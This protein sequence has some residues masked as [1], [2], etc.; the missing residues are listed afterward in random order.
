MNKTLLK[1][2]LSIF[3][4]NE[5]L[6][7]EK[8]KE[9]NSENNLRSLI[10]TIFL[11]ASSID[12]KLHTKLLQTVY[13]ESF[14]KNY[15]YTTLYIGPNKIK[16]TYIL[17]TGSSIMSSPCAPCDKCGPH[18]NNYYNSELPK[19]SKPLK[20]DN[21]PCKFVP[22]TNCKYKKDKEENKQLC[23]FD[24]K[25]Q[26]DD[27]MSGYYLNDIVYFE[28]DTNITSPIQKQV[29]RS[30]AL[31]IGCTT[32]EYGKYKELNAD[33]IIGL[34]YNEKSFISLLYNLKIINQD[35]FSLCFGLRGGYMSLGEVDTTYHKN[36]K[37]DYVPLLTSDEFYLI[38]IKGIEI[39]DNN[40]T[41]YSKSEAIIDTGNTISYFPIY[42]YKS[43]IKEFNEYCKKNDGKCG[44][45]KF[46]QELGYCA[47]F[48]DRGSLFKTIYKYWPNI[49]LELS[50]NKKYIWKPINYYYYSFEK[51]TRKRKACLGFNS[52]KSQ[53]IILG[54]NFIHDHDIIFDRAN[55]QLGFVQADCSRGNI[56]WKRR[57]GFLSKLPLLRNDPLLIDRAIHMGENEGKYNF[58]DNNTKDMLDFIQ[59]HNTELDFS[60]DF[61]LVNFIVLLSSI[62]VVVVVFAI[63]ISALMCNKRGYLKYDIP[64]AGQYME[65]IRDENATNKISFE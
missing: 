3:L 41:I 47:S 49:T 48:E 23:S 28:A 22:A 60:G 31:P 55:K 51:D 1:I 29:Y 52:H 59:G 62:I 7:Q 57:R 33:G 25:Q 21:K 45:F 36:N 19:K 34:N 20:C 15:Y 2:L 5:Y 14:S 37:I 30:Y 32:G 26:T 35:I 42:L 11:N 12:L 13:S 63:V 24:I 8:L 17:D 46:E 38:K 43:L 56:L 65:E 50:K 40:N 10:P 9:I 18:K 54:T 6:A 64:K 44:N 16:Q 58:G 4:L 27:G 53:N 61:Q 39:G